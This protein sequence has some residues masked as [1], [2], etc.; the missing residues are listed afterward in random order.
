MISKMYL[1]MLFLLIVVIG[2]VRGPEGFMDRLYLSGPTKCF[3]CERDMINR[4]G[5]QYAYLGKPS[6]CFSCEK[7]FAHSMSPGY[8]VLGQPT[9][10]FS[11]EKQYLN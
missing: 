2:L 7:Q 1:V 10:C 5:P 3:S 9:K 11:C 4:Y 8:A 6:K